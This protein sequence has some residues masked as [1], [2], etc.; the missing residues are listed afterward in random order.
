[1]GQSETEKFCS[2]ISMI[3]GLFSSHASVSYLMRWTPT[4]P[5][6]AVTHP[7]P[8]CSRDAAVIQTAV[9]LGVWCGRQMLCDQAAG[10][11]YM[12]CRT[13]PGLKRLPL[14]K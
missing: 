10:A 14:R 13:Q 2:S 5:W 4:N 6:S 1:M 3:W 11:R 12:V 7:F 8:G 9:T